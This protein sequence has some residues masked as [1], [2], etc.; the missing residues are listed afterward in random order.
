VER[1][2][3]HMNLGGQSLTIV[4]DIAALLELRGEEKGP[5]GREVSLVILADVS[6]CSGAIY[7]V[8]IRH[9]TVYRSRCGGG[10][11]RRQPGPVPSLWRVR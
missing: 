4:A 3:R 1:P 5:V 10:C 9:P 11:V 7:G 8:Q 6:L 2:P